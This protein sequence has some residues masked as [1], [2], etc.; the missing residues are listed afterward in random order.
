MADIDVAKSFTLTLDDGQKHTF[1]SGKQAVEPDLAEH[2][3]V[4]AHL[5]GA[6]SRPPAGSPAALKA[7][8]Q[9]KAA[10]AKARADEEA[11]FQAELLA[12]ER[13]KK[14]ADLAAKT[15]E[16]L[17]TKAEADAKAAGRPGK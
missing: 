16:A 8:A 9:A 13:T 2:W 6:E 15:A 3:Y 17:K 14:E 1:Q 5:V 7:D 12:E 10:A 11:A 4:R